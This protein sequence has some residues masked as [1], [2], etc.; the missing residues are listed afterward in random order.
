MSLT[1]S[2]GDGVTVITFTPNPES[3]W[4][5]MCQILGNL[6]YSPVCSAAQKLKGKL[7]ETQTALGIVQMIVGVIC[8]VLGAILEGNNIF[9]NLMETKAPFWLGGVFLA[10][11][12]VCILAAKFPS[13]CLLVIA[14]SLNMA[15]AALAITAVVLCSV[16]LAGGSNQNCDYYDHSGY[17]DN[18]KQLKENCLYYKHLNQMILGGLDII[19]IVLAVLQLCVTISFSVLTLKALCKKSG[20][21]QE[22]Q[23]HEPL[24]KGA[25][26]NPV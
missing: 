8:I 19:L 3:K 18:K 12:I 22:P 4:P 6:C 10:I 20:T 5:L 2:Q 7:T 17:E 16:D 23:L 13:P 25:A 11:G 15:S 21:A 9:N 1:M 14:V 24:L 26:A